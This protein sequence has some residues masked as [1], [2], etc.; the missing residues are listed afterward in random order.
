MPIENEDL[1]LF[2]IIYAQNA[3][4]P[5]EFIQEQVLKAKEALLANNRIIASMLA[6]KEAAKADKSIKF[7]EISKAD[8]AI[9]SRAEIDAAIEDDGIT[10]C[11]CRKKMKS[12]G[13]H[14]KRVHHVRPKDYIRVCG[15]PEDT[16]LM[17]KTLL[18]KVR[19]NVRIAQAKRTGS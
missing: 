5:M 11:I 7:V 15:Y 6:E 12:L 4:K 14:L 1:Q 16:K 10:C 9:K 17:G 19:E 18:A 2:Q 13:M 8:L 3:D